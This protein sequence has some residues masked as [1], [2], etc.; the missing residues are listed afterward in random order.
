MGMWIGWSA[1]A[2]AGET[3]PLE[4]LAWEVDV[5]GPFAELTLVERFRNTADHPVDALYVFP[6]G[7]G[8]AVD[9]VTLR[10]ETRE[11]VGRIQ[12]RDE[13]RA[14]YEAARDEGRVASLAASAGGDVFTQDVANVAPGVA[15][16]VELH[17]VTP[18]TW[19]DGA[20][21]L[22]LPLAAPPRFLALGSEPVLPAAG[23]GR[24]VGVWADV[25]V[26]VR[27]AAGVRS[28]D[29]EPPT[30]AAP[31]LWGSTGTLALDDLP[32][33]RDLHLRWR[34]ALDQPLTGL[35]VTSTHALVVREPGPLGEVAWGGCAVTEVST[36]S[37]GDVGWAIG[38][39][40][41]PCRG[42]VTV[43]EAVVWPRVA[44]A[45]VGR[46]LAAG[47]ARGRADALA[48][49]PEAVRRLGLE[50]GIAT[51]E[52]SFVAVDPGTDGAKA[53]RLR[54]AQEVWFEP[55]LDSRG[56]EYVMVM[57]KEQ[58]VDTSSTTRG[59]VLTG[60]LVTGTFSAHFNF[61]AVSAVEALGWGRMPDVPGGDGVHVWTRSGT[62]QLDAA[63]TV[64]AG[65]LSPGTW[66]SGGGSASL[67]GPL[68]RD[69]VWFVAAADAVERRDLGLTVGSRRAFGKLTAQPNPGHRFELEGGAEPS[70]LAGEGVA[71]RWGGASGLA[72][73]QWFL[74]PDVNLD[75]RLT[76]GRR[77]VAGVARDR[78][79]LASQVQ[80][81]SVDDALGGVHDLGAGV[82]GGQLGA[83]G[84]SATV[85]SAYAQDRWNPVTALLVAGGA[86][87]EAVDRR[88][89]PGPRLF[90][91]W[92][93]FGDQRTKLSAGGARYVAVDRLL[94][95]ADPPIT[96]ELHAAAERELVS[97]FALGVAGT[98]ARQR[99]PFAVS[100][101]L[102]PQGLPGP[103]VDRGVPALELFAHK[104]EARRWALEASYRWTARVPVEPALA[105]DPLARFVPGYLAALRPHAVEATLGWDLPTD[106]WTLHLGG[107]ARWS[108]AVRGAVRGAGATPWLGDAVA[109]GVAAN[110]DLDLRKGGELTAGVGVVWA[111]NDDAASFLP[112][113]A[114]VLAP[115]VALTDQ[116]PLRV[117]GS[118]RWSW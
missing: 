98:L 64:R 13:A 99:F 71:A 115:G 61:D 69:H 100:P 101:E 38:R 104:V 4:T 62:N 70:S 48:G 24:D 30:A 55:D 117:E 16:E 2:A 21:H 41:G 9:G 15:V 43:G 54:E 8:D 40:T 81:L 92:D 17:V 67:A 32:L 94:P 53:A 85:V 116:P 7:P 60:D 109:V 6:L 59:Q 114:F 3:L 29:A 66:A 111:V 26:V 18:V 68:A 87:V 79:E 51:S 93:P 72:R 75:T 106:P 102:R 97:D 89:F 47:W 27:A 82:G 28:L 22:R 83:A 84:W 46:A 74:S 25:R 44:P 19:E 42:P 118:L 91:A 5:V 78:W 77:A 90:V 52:T 33:G 37:S 50:W 36:G 14:T 23:V 63:L 95:G 73:W 103:L 65:A 88:V 56:P 49:D 76:G 34:T 12:G 112:L 57:A 10:V 110:Q 35:L 113:E 58:A 31:D 105:G 1:V 108:S 11:L 20:W 86:R 39:R 80:A 107:F 45:G 96:D